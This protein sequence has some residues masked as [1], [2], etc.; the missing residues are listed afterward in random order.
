MPKSSSLGHKYTAKGRAHDRSIKVY[1]QIWLPSTAFLSSSHVPAHHHHAAIVYLQ[2][3]PTWVTLT[4]STCRAPASIFRRGLKDLLSG[5][6]DKDKTC[7]RLEYATKSA[8]GEEPIE[9]N[10]ADEQASFL[11]HQ[12]KHNVKEPRLR[13]RCAVYELNS[14][15]IRDLAIDTTRLNVDGEQCTI[16]VKG[17]KHYQLLLQ[18]LRLPYSGNT[19]LPTAGGMMAMQIKT[20][21]EFVVGESTV[22]TVERNRKKRMRGSAA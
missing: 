14:I 2:P 13:N 11:A 1:S 7:L 20:K 21:I 18:A 5:A 16:F 12:H 19:M 8:D 17:D 9:A 22:G 10:K 3:P 15:V 6:G 4:F